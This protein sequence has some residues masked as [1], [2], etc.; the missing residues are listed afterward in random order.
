MFDARAVALEAVA[1][2]WVEPS[3]LWEAAVRF[4]A[5]RGSL[6]ATELLPS[7]SADRVDELFEARA[8][9]PTMAQAFDGTIPPPSKETRPGHL[10]GPRYTLDDLL[11]VGGTGQ[12]MAALDREVR[13]V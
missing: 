8:D 5:A 4:V 3:E 10:I 11:G 9:V 13:R 12:V 2:G 1:R 6:R 7:L